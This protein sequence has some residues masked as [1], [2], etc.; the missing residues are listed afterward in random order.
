MLTCIVGRY[1]NYY[2]IITVLYHTISYLKVLQHVRQKDLWVGPTI[3]VMG[4]ANLTTHRRTDFTSGYLK[5]W[6]NSWEE[7]S[8]EKYCR[9]RKA[10]QGTSTVSGQVWSKSF[11]PQFVH[12]NIHILASMSI[13]CANSYSKINMEWSK[14]GKYGL[15]KYGNGKY[16]LVFTNTKVKVSIP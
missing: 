14:Y 2:Q 1:L 16:G 6:G 7:V 11:L 12:G 3:R 5:G 10:K 9:S 8:I 13:S 15:G 4:Q